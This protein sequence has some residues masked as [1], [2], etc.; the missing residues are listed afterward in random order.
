M[1]T[2]LQLSDGLIE[3]LEGLSIRTSEGSFVKVEDVRRLINEKKQAATTN[4]LPER[5][6]VVQA[7]ERAKEFLKDALG[8]VAPRESGRAIPATEAQPPS[9]A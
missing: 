3:A 6:T 5:M 1:S 7:R 4:A 9:R 8:P 2:D